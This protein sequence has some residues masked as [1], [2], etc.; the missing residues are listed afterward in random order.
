MTM[1]LGTNP[2]GTHRPVG[3]LT[4]EDPYINDAFRSDVNLGVV[5]IHGAYDSEGTLQYYVLTTVPAEEKEPPTKVDP[6][7]YPED[8]QL[9]A[10]S[11]NEDGIH[12]IYSKKKFTVEE[13]ERKLELARHEIHELKDRLSRVTDEFRCSAMYAAKD[14]I[15]ST[16]KHLEGPT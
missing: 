10:L 8:Y 5:G 6:F 12:I 11:E 3:S 4:I 15:L 9:A 1:L 2:D 16:V 7:D 14:E 13:L